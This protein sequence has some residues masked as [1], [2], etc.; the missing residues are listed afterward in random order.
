MRSFVKLVLAVVLAIV[1]YKNL[2]SIIGLD[3]T[4][5]FIVLVVAA[6]FLAFTEPGRELARAILLNRD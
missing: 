4:L 1:I 2:V 6:A 5:G 3:M